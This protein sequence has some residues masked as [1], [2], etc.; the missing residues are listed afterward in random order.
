MGRGRQHILCK[1]LA[2][3]RPTLPSH[4]TY[5]RVLG[6]AIE[7]AEL[8]AIVTEHLTQPAGA[9]QSVLVA[10]DGKTLRGNIPVGETRGMHL[11]AAYLPD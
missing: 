6:D 7:Q 3:N 9:G 2:V 5:R 8:Q 1:V 10:L 4:N 11:L